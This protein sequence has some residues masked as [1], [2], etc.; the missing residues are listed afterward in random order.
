VELSCVTG[1]PARAEN[2]SG[3]FFAIKR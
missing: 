2:R 1:L 3:R